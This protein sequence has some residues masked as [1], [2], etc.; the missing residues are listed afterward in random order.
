M[1]TKMETADFPF[2]GMDGLPN[3]LKDYVGSDNGV[4]NI[5]FDDC[6]RIDSWTDSLSEPLAGK[7]V[8]FYGKSTLYAELGSE[9]VE[10]FDP[11]G[12]NEAK[13]GSLTVRKF[14][15]LEDE[16]TSYVD[17]IVQV[18]EELPF[19]E[20]MT[21][22]RFKIKVRGVICWDKSD[23]RKDYMKRGP[24]WVKSDNLSS[25]ILNSS[26]GVKLRSEEGARAA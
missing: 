7:R 22:P 11:T 16:E 6:R 10:I 15:Y 21:L 18:D 8:E 23:E 20:G 26:I 2:H 25:L 9:A 5:W 13:I 12:D 1:I 24:L 19:S 3:H 17:R 4:G 14:S